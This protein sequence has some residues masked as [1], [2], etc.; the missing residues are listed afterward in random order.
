MTLGETLIRLII[1]V[2]FEK[3]NQIEISF[4]AAATNQIEKSIMISIKILL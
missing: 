3:N 1:V 2:N 4:P